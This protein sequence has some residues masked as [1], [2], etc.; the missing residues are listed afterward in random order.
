MIAFEQLTAGQRNAYDRSL[1]QIKNKKKHILIN[2][3]AGT[4][5]TT[6]TKFL[7]DSL[8]RSGESGIILAA[9]T[10][11]AKKVLAKMSGMEAATI[12]SILK[13]NPTTYEE[14]TIFEQ[15]EMP[16]LASCRVLICDEWSMY[17][18]KL[19]DILM[20]TIP[21]WCTVIA[22]GD[23]AQIRPVA[24][25]DSGPVK[26][27]PFY[28]DV[29]F[30]HCYLD[31]VMRSNAPI[32]EVA[33]EIR[34]GGWIRENIVNGHGVHGFTGDNA[35]RN[36]M[37]QYFDIVRTPEDMFENRMYAYTNKSVDTLNS[38]IR[39]KIYKTEEPFIVGEVLVMQEP[40]MREMKFEGKKF[41]EIIFNN[42]Q[43]IR[44][45]NA[46]QTS[47]F[48]KAKGVS[49][50]YMIRYWVLEVESIDESEEYAKAKLNVIYDKS[51]LDKFQFFLSKVATAYKSGEVKAHW[52]DFW[53][54][55]RIFSKVKPLPVSTIHKS[56][57]S[58]VDSSFLYTPCIHMADTDLA[59]QLLYVGS[60]RARND[61]YFV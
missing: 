56:Q 43:Q 52:K 1:Y 4:G 22:L 7:I 30:E 32:I 55:K 2:G 17:D 60:T 3:P 8:V 25:G 13:I 21:S 48:L 23:K 5:K 45:L 50:E 47:T 42:G 10:H 12:H 53:S 38:I 34:E 6:L 28:T 54:A 11:Q 9:P 46:T 16:D 20:N 31:E 19:F 49:G 24:P 29:R 36:F 57:G 58:S 44:V 35:L 51:E 26:V 14:N 18:R 61:V 37:M 59:L 15:R 27:S 33:T 40:F 41:T 39:R